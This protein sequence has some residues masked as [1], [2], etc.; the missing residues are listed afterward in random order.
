MIWTSDVVEE[1]FRRAKGE[2]AARPV[3]LHSEQRINAHLTTVMGALAF[4][5]NLLDRTGLSIRRILHAPEPLRSSRIRFGDQIL[6]LPPT[7]SP[8]PARQILESLDTDV[9]APTGR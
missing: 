6:E 1:P 3:Y 4:T 9:K 5:R 7:D 8:E 2:L